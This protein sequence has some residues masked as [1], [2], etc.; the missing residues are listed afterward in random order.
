MGIFVSSVIITNII[1]IA[2]IVHA[3]NSRHS[4]VL[5]RVIL[6]SFV[7]VKTKYVVVI[8]TMQLR[9]VAYHQNK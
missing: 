1:K 6:I 7:Y 2:E 5:L 9:C 8:W 3:E 4:L